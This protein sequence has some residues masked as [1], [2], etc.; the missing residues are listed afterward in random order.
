MSEFCVYL[1]PDGKKGKTDKVGEFSLLYTS[2][3]FMKYTLRSYTEPWI[4]KELE[5]FPKCEN[6]TLWKIQGPPWATHVELRVH[7][8]GSSSPAPTVKAKVVWYRYCLKWCV[9][10][11]TSVS[12][13]SGTVGRHPH[14]CTVLKV[15][16]KKMHKSIKSGSLI[17]LCNRF[18]NPMLYI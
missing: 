13:I 18:W 4:L 14:L 9:K 12:Q 16:L 11:T 1:F 3:L 10:N 2:C 15:G 17:G 8:L 6:V 7:L 5:C